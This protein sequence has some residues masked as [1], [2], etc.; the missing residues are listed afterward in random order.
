MT[1][2]AYRTKLT[3]HIVSYA[4]FY[5]DSKLILELYCIFLV[6]ITNQQTEN[7]IPNFHIRRWINSIIFLRI[8][9]LHPEEN[10]DEVFS[11]LNDLQK[12]VMISMDEEEPIDG[13]FN[14]TSHSARESFGRNLIEDSFIINRPEPK[15]RV[16]R[17]IN[18]ELNAGL[19]DDI[20]SSVDASVDEQ[21][22][23]TSTED[24]NHRQLQI[25]PRD[26]ENHLN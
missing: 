6:L 13:S 8:L 4:I 17:D 21:S 7:L 14:V 10:N 2:F 22:I 20:S 25:L 1:L 18:S 5:Y 19:M 24:R 3:F 26:F 15:R 23:N 11:G 12:D 9:G 16:P